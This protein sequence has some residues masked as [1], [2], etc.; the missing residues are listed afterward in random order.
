MI[1]NSKRLKV[2]LY[3][4]GCKLNQAELELMARD[5][6]RAGY[7]VVSASAEAD[8]YVLNTCTVTHIA[9]RKSRQWLRFARRK[10][11]E[12]LLV[13]TG[14]Y[15]E[16][17]PEALNRLEGVNLVIGNAEKPGLVEIVD[18]YVGSPQFDHEDIASA[19][20]ADGLRTRTLV[21]VQDG[22]N[23]FCS[24]CI[25]PLT[26]GREVSL[27]VEMVIDE[28]KRR[29]AGGYKEVV[30]TG[31]KI[32]AYGY[33][34]VALKGLIERILA[35]TNVS[36]LRLSS[37]QPQEISAGLV[38]LWHEPRLC[39]HFHLSLQSGSDTVLTRMNRRYLTADYRQMVAL[40]CSVVPEAAITTDIIAGFP[41]ETDAEF[42]TGYAFAREMAFARIHVFAYSPR[43]G[44]KA[45]LMPH[46]VPFGIKKERSERLLALAGESALSFRERF[47]GREMTVLWE[48]EAGGN[49]SGLTDNYI[50]VYTASR[51]NLANRLT[52]VKLTAVYRDGVWGEVV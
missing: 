19:S 26:R 5:F 51:D 36:R 25:V 44:T 35:G 20:F 29:V 46:P 50:R 18:K 21:K 49:W 23:N 16:R 17:A 40:I 37:L 45:A 27:P 32:G 24:Y 9:D 11:P 48:Q 14:C 43:A 10:N 41:G 39:R 38:A 13:A 52:P 47:L 1:E 42:E 7:Q 22:C 6:T 30:L 28:V 3:S 33:D 12:A 34:G 8:I 2:A 4:L 15:A 31:V